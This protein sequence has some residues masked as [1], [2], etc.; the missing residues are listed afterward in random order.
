VLLAEGNF[1]KNRY[2]LV[3]L[4]AVSKGGLPNNETLSQARA[5]TIIVGKMQKI[6][7]SLFELD[8]RQSH[9]RSTVRDLPA[10][11][12]WE[13]SDQGIPAQPAFVPRKL[14]ILHAN[15][16]WEAPHLT[17]AQWEILQGTFISLRL[18]LDYFRKYRRRKPL[19]SDRCLLE[20][21]L[22]KLANGLR[23]RDLEGKYPAR[24][25]QELYSALVRS[26]RM[27]TVYNRLRGYLEVNGGTTLLGLVERG[28]FV[29]SGNRVLLAPSEKPTWQKYTALLLLQQAYHARRSIRL[30]FDRERRRMGGYY[31]IPYT[32]VRRSPR[33]SPGFHTKQSPSLKPAWPTP[34]QSEDTGYLRLNIKFHDTESVGKGFLYGKIRRSK[35]QRK[36]DP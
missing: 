26:G 24:R 33:C 36:P 20:G 13:F 12:R 34:G 1:F 5:A 16:S 4:L 2:K 21:I 31:R 32:G 10:L 27:Q 29:I 9:L 18:D 22:W 23:W 17:D 6:Y 14:N 3:G 28:R 11:L 8:G 25:C 35:I 15:L 19:P 30:E 7:R